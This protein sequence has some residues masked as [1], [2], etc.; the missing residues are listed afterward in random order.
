MITTIENSMLEMNM[1]EKNDYENELERTGG[2]I[3]FNPPPLYT[4]QSV[5][6]LLMFY[7]L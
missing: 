7:F 2:D 6:H 3:S 4:R 1:N 5:I